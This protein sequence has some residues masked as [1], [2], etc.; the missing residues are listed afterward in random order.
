MRAGRYPQALRAR[1]GRG[2]PPSLL[3]GIS[4]RRKSRN[5][6]PWLIGIVGAFGVMILLFTIVFAITTA[7]AV[8][9]TLDEYRDV[10]EGLP[11]AA[12][13]V[14]GT[15]QTTRIYDRNGELL[16]EVAD[17]DSGWRTFV[18]L[19][20]VSQYLIDATVASEDATFWSHYGVEP[21]AI[22][23]GAL[24]GA[25]AG[26]LSGVVLIWF[27]GPKAYEPPSIPSV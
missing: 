15:F 16:Q 1:R 19:E 9:G 12:G 8:A 4:R 23:R 5:L 20:D 2:L 13:V 17:P 10:N 14:A 25:C 6:A 21:F 26:A 7:V 3:P 27:A 22:V 18:P 24:G 11:N